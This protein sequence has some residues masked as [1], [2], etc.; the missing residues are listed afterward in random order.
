MS[1]IK[2]EERLPNHN[3][4]VLA[5]TKSKAQAVVI[6][7]NDKLTTMFLEKHGFNYPD[8]YKG[9]AFCSQEIKGNTL[10]GVTHWRELPKDPSEDLN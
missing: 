8:E 10:N 4:T 6:F 7:L 5:R 2:V 1:W 3:S 9:N